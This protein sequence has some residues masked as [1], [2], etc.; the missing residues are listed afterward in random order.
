MQFLTA[1][2]LTLTPTVAVLAAPA[3]KEQAQEQARAVLPDGF[4]VAEIF[5]NGTLIHTSIDNPKAIPIVHEGLATSILSARAL[6]A[7]SPDSNKLSRRKTDCW[8]RMLDATGI[9]KAVQKWKDYLRQYTTADVKTDGSQH[10]L[11]VH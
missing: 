5:D 7:E 6:A 2:L 9:D 8:G 1:L 3:S 4:Y 11:A 10:L